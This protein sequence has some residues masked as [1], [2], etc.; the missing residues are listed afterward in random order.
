[1]SDARPE[2]EFVTRTALLIAPAPERNADPHMLDGDGRFRLP[3]GVPL[4][5]FL[6]SEREQLDADDFRA[7]DGSDRLPVL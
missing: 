6:P 5:M 2:S 4:A 7:T 3:A 1:M